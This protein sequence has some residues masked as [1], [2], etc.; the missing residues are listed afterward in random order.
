MPLFLLRLKIQTVVLLLLVI[1]A[2]LA[3]CQRNK[4]EHYRAEGER[5]AAAGQTNE[6][7]QAFAQA[8]RLKPA[9]TEL[10]LRLADTYYTAG[11]HLN[12]AP[13]YLALRQ[14]MPTNELVRQRS[15]ELLLEFQQYKELQS[16]LAGE[17]RRQPPPWWALDYQGDYLF[18]QQ[19]YDDALATWTRLLSDPHLAESNRFEVQLKEG[20][21]LFVAGK[22]TEAVAVIDQLVARKADFYD[23]LMLKA[24]YH[25]AVGQTNEATA[26]Y[27]QL[28]TRFP[29]A[30]EP[31]IGL[32]AL[33]VERQ[34]IDQAISLYQQAAV[35][36]PARVDTVIWL[37]ELYFQ[38]SDK[39]ALEK[40][41]PP[42]SP[43]HPE[44]EAAGR[45]LK[46][47][48]FY[49]AGDLPSALKEL[50]AAQLYMVGYPG[51]Q[52]KLGQTFLRL[53][54]PALAEKAFAQVS[55][56]PAAQ[57]II[58]SALAQSYMAD[59]N[60]LRAL[61]WLRVV[62]EDTHLPQLAEAQFGVGD[63]REALR[64]A[65]RWLQQDP[66]A[67]TAHLIAAE[68][69]L[70]LNRT[71]EQT[72]QFRQLA[73]I[74]P[75]TPAG[76]Y[77]R[78]QLLLGENKLEEAA[79]LLEANRTKLEG[80][81]GVELALGQIRFRQKHFP[82][83]KQHL[84][85][86]L[87]M[88]PSLARAQSLLGVMAL[89]DGKKA[90]AKTAF[91]LALKWRPDD[92]PALLGMGFTEYNDGHFREAVNW[93]EQLPRTN[94]A[95]GQAQ[96]VITLSEFQLGRAE[97]ALASANRA[98]AL[99]PDDP[100]A[101]YFAVRAQVWNR[102]FAGAQRTLALCTQRAPDF[103]MN[104]HAAAVLALAQGKTAAALQAAAEGAKRHPTN[105]LLRTLEVELERTGGQLDRSITDAR[106]LQQDFPKDPLAWLAVANG[107][108]MK[109]D[110][111]PAREAIRQG[112]ALAPGDTD[113]RQR[114]L[115]SYVLAGR[116]G[117]A[118]PE[119]EKMLQADPDNRDLLF[120]CARLQAA[121][122]DVD[123]AEGHY[124]QLLKL[125]PR[126]A[127]ALN[128]LASLLTSVAAKRD[129][130]VKLAERAYTV[131][132]DNGAIQDTLGYLYLLT[133]DSQRALLMLRSAAAALPKDPEVGFHLAEALVREGQL[134]EARQQISKLEKLP[135]HERIA[136][137][138]ASL[139][140]QLEK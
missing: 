68:S 125:D 2:G 96:M 123:A 42:D 85:Q 87:K 34:Q 9:D 50:Q 14:M 109:R 120:M 124:R 122:G 25:L 101:G 112:L 113:L 77:A 7:M 22:K 65:T 121:A 37:A 116:V 84:E 136:A 98:W 138:L 86:A 41:R 62:D 104:Y 60:Y 137:S 89:N 95:Q 6:S 58:W 64:A 140:A 139:K 43:D 35:L 17:L 18:A 127:A 57:R 73:Q 88:E 54:Q 118:A 83:A 5:L 10:R 44:A 19:R 8:L 129:D 131:Q 11:R 117:E 52:E 93:L 66:K 39:A 99:L 111:V 106:R 12:A 108:L 24:N 103:A 31:L 67:M 75:D 74:S 79:S 33:A 110:Y 13:Q 53:G 78:S 16:T 47:L 26:A 59:R 128:N 105:A 32:A 107:L 76:I 134:A 115:D 23:A 133:G 81:A 91:Q 48:R 72:D 21:A 114:L 100:Q 45:Y 27:T 71:A 135:G 4:Y 51:V 1:W 82:E 55:R 20:R 69:A 29:K 132:G 3:G 28:R 56:E 40:L 102:D 46:G 92:Q 15:A 38:R 49:L 63:Y 70:R 97:R 119:F 61:Y 94:A 80:M 130:A 126:N 90:E 36:N 30:D